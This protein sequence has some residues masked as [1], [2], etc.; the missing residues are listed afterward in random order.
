MLDQLAAGDLPVVIQGASGRMGRRHTELMKAYGTKVVAGVGRSHTGGAIAGVPIFV[1]CAE[2]VAQTGATVSVTLV[3]PLEVL[4]AVRE[5]VEA[6]VGLIV[7]P[8]EGMP[9]HDALQACVLTH[10]KGVVW[11]GPS[12][13]GVAVPGRMKLGF[14]P[15]AALAPGHL[16]IMSKSG[17]LAYES[18]FRLKSFGIGQSLWVG[19]G[20]DPVKGVRFAD[21]LPAFAKDSGTKAIL[22][23]GEIGGTEEEDLAEAIIKT[24]FAKPIFVLLAGSSAP[25]GVTMG[26]AGA[27]VMGGRGSNKSKRE[28]LQNAGA[29][30]FPSLS[31]LVEGI[32]NAM[33]SHVG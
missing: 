17:T 7:T 13:P 18:A 20:G 2:A 24:G 23:V 33:A 26:H 15:D 16:G 6:G 29:S 14:I 1:S 22:V 11:V 21:M 30:V 10:E 3:P 32:R 25:E 19:V 28:A 9:V 31:E 12:T 27:I 8:T 4:G 5:A